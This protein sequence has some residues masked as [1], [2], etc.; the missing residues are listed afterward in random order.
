MDGG[1]SVIGWWERETGGRDVR[2]ARFAPR[3]IGEIN[4]R[5]R[6]GPYLDVIA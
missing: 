3:P 5:P 6:S 1:A 2:T 4:A